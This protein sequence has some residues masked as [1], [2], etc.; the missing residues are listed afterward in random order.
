MRRS[1]RR[2]AGGGLPLCPA[3]LP[4]ARGAGCWGAPPDAGQRRQGASLWPWTDPTVSTK[5]YDTL[6]RPNGQLPELP[7][8]QFDGHAELRG[9]RCWGIGGG[10]PFEAATLAAA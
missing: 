3:A 8:I 4:L 6:R 1:R 2:D 5:V 10:A 7:K 9:A